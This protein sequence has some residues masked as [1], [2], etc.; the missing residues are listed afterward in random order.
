MATR[1]TSR[2]RVKKNQAP[3]KEGAFFRF[4]EADN[5]VFYN[6]HCDD[7]EDKKMGLFTYFALITKYTQ[8]FFFFVKNQIFGGLF[9]RK[10]C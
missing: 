1:K 7:N 8:R 4:L 2:A 3:P 5:Y 6:S 10:K 9:L